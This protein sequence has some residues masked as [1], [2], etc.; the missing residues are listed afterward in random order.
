ME[1]KVVR[2]SRKTIV[3]NV[4]EQGEVI[5]K[6]PL[7]TTK[8]IIDKIVCDNMSWINEQLIKRNKHISSYDYIRTGNILYYG[9]Y[10]NIDFITSNN[11]ANISYALN[12]GFVI[13]TSG[14][15]K[16]IRRI[17]EEFYRQEAREYLEART[18]YW[19]NKVGVKYNKISI[20]KQKTRWGSCSSNGNLSYNLKLVCAPTEMIDYVVLHEVMHLRHLNHGNTFW[21][22]LEEYMPDYRVRSEYFDKFGQN[23]II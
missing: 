5:V 1:Y 22:E 12:K 19:A 16:D 21:K 2:S 17:V 13:E 4:N 10:I 3:I 8:K 15:E 20:R 9:E 6:T 23:F 7:K 18:R 11:K 14:A